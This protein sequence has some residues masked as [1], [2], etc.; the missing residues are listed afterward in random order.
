ME[1]STSP[2]CPSPPSPVD[3]AL[4]PSFRNLAIRPNTS[5]YFGRSLSWC[6][7][8]RN[9]SEDSSLS[10]P[11]VSGRKLGSSQSSNSL[12]TSA[13]SLAAPAPR[14]FGNDFELSD[15]ETGAC[16]AGEGED[17]GLKGSQQGSRVRR[18]KRG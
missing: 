3:S 2:T 14:S 1:A 6:A 13:I 18:R 10:E 15:G 4:S 12:S 16:V 7:K 9:G 17:L 8:A 11:K 5:D